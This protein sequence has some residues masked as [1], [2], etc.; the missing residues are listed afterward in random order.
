MFTKPQSFGQDINQ[1]MQRTQHWP[2]H[3]SINTSFVFK[4]VS[5][6]PNIMFDTDLFPS[7]FPTSPGTLV[8]KAGLSG[9]G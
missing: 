4:V 2:T 8:F 1:G 5:I 9:S 3:N 6:G 7:H